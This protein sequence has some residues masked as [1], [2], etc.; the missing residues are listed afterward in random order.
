MEN[1]GWRLLIRRGY[2]G[3]AHR[4]ASGE[5]ELRREPTVG[6]GRTPHPVTTLGDGERAVIRAFR[7][8]GVLR[9]L[10][11]GRYFGGHRAFMEALATE[12]AR[13]AGARVPT[14]I[15]AAERRERVGYTAR[16]VTLWIP[17]GTEAA[18]WLPGATGEA[19]REALRDAGEQI[20]RM[21]ASGVA[22]PDLNLRNLLVVQNEEGDAPAVYLLDFDR[23]R[24]F[25]GRVPRERRARDLRRMARSARKLR[26]PIDA[27]GWEA[28]RE[29]YGADWPLR[30]DLG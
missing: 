26:A 22:H 6:G 20:G 3:E 13:D 1:G 7:R 19:R 5:D 28:L 30:S 17:G 16:L 10:N 23:A 27:A 24:L 25:S 4:F 11:R 21:H 9:H 29:G 8:G 2:E 12:R 18:A 14:T 15:A